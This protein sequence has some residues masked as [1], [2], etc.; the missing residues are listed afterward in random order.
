MEQTFT[1]KEFWNTLQNKPKG[2]AYTEGEFKSPECID[3]KYVR[4]ARKLVRD[5]RD[6]LNQNIT[7]KKW[8]LVAERM[9]RG[10]GTYVLV[11]TLAIKD[12]RN[13]VDQMKV[14]FI[15]PPLIPKTYL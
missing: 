4:R 15:A 14:E 5:Y 11:Y 12:G 1:F 6:I 3:F 8:Q 13:I 10:S 2:I 7:G 9:Y